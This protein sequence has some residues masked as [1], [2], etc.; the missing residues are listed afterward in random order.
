MKTILYWC[1]KIL[2]ILIQVWN[3]TGMLRRLNLV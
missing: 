3:E 1:C 2:Q